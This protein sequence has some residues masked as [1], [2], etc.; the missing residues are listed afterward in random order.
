[1]AHRTVPIF[2]NLSVVPVETR[3]LDGP[4]SRRRML[5]NV[6]TQSVGKFGE[7]PGILIST[8]MVAALLWW[9]FC[10]VFPALAQTSDMTGAWTTDVSVCDQIFTKRSGKISFRTGAHRHGKGFILEERRIRGRVAT[11]KIDWR[12]DR[13]QLAATC[14]GNVI[15]TA[16]FTLKVLDGPRFGLVV[17]DRTNLQIY[18]RCA[19]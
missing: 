10:P 1:M 8:T 7:W 5:P 16:H 11:C 18:Q 2:E 3:T 19:L 9:A 4:N 13:T 12:P 17:S 15:D 14:T 6:M